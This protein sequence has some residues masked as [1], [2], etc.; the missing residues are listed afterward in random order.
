MDVKMAPW[1][2]KTSLFGFG[3]CELQLFGKLL[4]VVADPSSQRNLVQI[5]PEVSRSDW[6]WQLPWASLSSESI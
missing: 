1:L 3:L 4:H 2:L 6:C 5:C